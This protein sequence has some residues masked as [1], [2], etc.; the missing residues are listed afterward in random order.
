VLLGGGVAAN[1]ELRKRLETNLKKELPNIKYLI[2]D[3]RMAGDNALM[4]AIAAHFTG[5][6]KAWNKVHADA[7]LRLS[8]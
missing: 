5:K 7:N 1:H 2:P 6:K 8:R 3:T 4:I